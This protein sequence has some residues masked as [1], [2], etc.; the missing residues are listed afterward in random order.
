MIF[1]LYKRFAIGWTSQ[2]STTKNVKQAILCTSQFY[3]AGSLLSGNS[4]SLGY[5]IESRAPQQISLIHVK[6][7]KEPSNGVV[8]PLAKE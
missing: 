6:S 3:K 5:V 4:L 7:Y 2:H 1:L 8:I